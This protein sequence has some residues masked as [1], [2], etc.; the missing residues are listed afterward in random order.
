VSMV[1]L[2]KRIWD[3]SSTTRWRPHRGRWQRLL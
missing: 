2:S 3:A 1:G